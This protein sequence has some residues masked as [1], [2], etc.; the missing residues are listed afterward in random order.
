[1]KIQVDQLR[2]NP[3]RRMEKYPINR[4][5]VESLKISITE[6]DFWDNILVRRVKGGFEIAYGHHRLI[7]LQ[8]LGIKEVELPVKELDN[9]LMIKIMANENLTEW[10][11]NPAV[12]NETVHAARDYLNSELA[13]VS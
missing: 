13:K 10:H 6:T 7:A 2:P 11:S 9:G 1:M 3:Y 8:E 12:I 4:E 5:K